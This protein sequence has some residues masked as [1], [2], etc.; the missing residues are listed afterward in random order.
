MT[1]AVIGGANRPRDA[2]SS[3]AFVASVA[4]TAPSRWSSPGPRW[5]PAPPSPAH[6][7]LMI[8]PALKRSAAPCRRAVP[9]GMCVP[10]ASI[11]LTLIEV[12]WQNK[13][14][15][16]VAARLGNVREKAGFPP[17]SC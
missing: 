8:Y 4:W 12:T 10:A 14:L 11:V 15:D 13:G 16:S 1:P 7:L 6:G 3:A 5:H 2:T 9:D 17:G